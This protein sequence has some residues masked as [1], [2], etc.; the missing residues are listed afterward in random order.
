MYIIAISIDC[1]EVMELRDE[2]DSP[3]GKLARQ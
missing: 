3:T 2:P 1:A